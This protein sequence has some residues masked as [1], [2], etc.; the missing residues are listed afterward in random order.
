MAI[1][2]ASIDGFLSQLILL[3]CFEQVIIIACTER[4][5]GK[6]LLRLARRGIGHTTPSLGDGRNR[7]ISAPILC[8]SMLQPK[9]RIE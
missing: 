4:E 1:R 9:F 8:V 5:S 7:R 3:G 2:S 6:L